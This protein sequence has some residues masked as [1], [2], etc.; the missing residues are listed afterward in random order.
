M[1]NIKLK[2]AK[3]I[4]DFGGIVNKDGKRI[5]QGCFIRSNAL[6]KLTADDVRILTQRYNLGTVIDLRIDTEIDEKPDVKIPGV[7]YIHIPVIRESTVGIS[8]ENE[9]DRKKALDSLPDLC[10]LYGSIITDDYSVSQL[11]KVFEIISANDTG[12]SVLW[13]CTEGKD[14]CGLTS[15]LFLSLLDVDIDTI[16][17]DYLFTNN[18]SSKN[19]R[20]YYFLVLLMSHSRE[21]AGQIKRIFRAEREY[22]DA[23][24]YE[25]NNKYGGMENFL[26][27]YIG[28]TDEIKEKMKAEYLV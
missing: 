27:D 14:R 10:Q 8:H 3:N 19:S 17:E 16:Y 6:D 18:A 9:T 7:E 4:R 1:E 22:L 5:K 13:H 21:K 23:A 26:R 24:F 12:K 28:I 20:K 25:I 15:A 11:K 2:G